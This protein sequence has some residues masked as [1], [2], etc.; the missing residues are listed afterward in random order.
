VLFVYGFKQNIDIMDL[1]RMQKFSPRVLG[2]TIRPEVKKAGKSGIIYTGPLAVE[3]ST[4]KG[5]QQSRSD[6]TGR[7][8]FSTRRTFGPQPRAEAEYTRQAPAFYGRERERERS[9]DDLPRERER[10][11]ENQSIAAKAWRLLMGD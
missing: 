4:S 8:D 6:P 5:E 2:V 1:D 9:T 7:A 3:F 11:G 10:R